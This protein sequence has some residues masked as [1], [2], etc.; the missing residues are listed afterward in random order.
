VKQSRLESL[1]E[2]FVDVASGF[3]VAMCVTQFI[4]VPLWDLPIGVLDNLGIT[5]IFTVTTFIRRYF[6]RRFFN[7]GVHKTIHNTIRRMRC[8]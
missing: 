5:T 8:K 7:A 2:T 3:L 6:W 1:I 4:I